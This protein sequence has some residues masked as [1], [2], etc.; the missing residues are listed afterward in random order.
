MSKT[1]EKIFLFI[2]DFIAINFAWSLHYY[3]RVE[4][5]FLELYT[6]VQF[7]LPMFVV[8]LFWVLVFG[9][10]GLYNSWYAKS[11][12]DELAQVFKAVTFGVILLFFIIFI[13]DSSNDVSGSNRSII[14]L[15]WLLLVFLCEFGRASIH[16]IQ[17]K[18]LLKGI[19]LQNTLIIGWSKKAKDLYD[20]IKK[21]P[22]LGYN[23]IGF[24]STNGNSE[25]E[26]HNNIKI[27]PGIKYLPSIIIEHQIKEVL[28]A[29]ESK[30]HDKLID[31]ISKCEPFRVGLKIMPDLYDIVT[32]QARTNQIYGFPLIDIMPQLMTNWERVIKRLLDLF[33][34]FIVLICFIPFWIL[35][36][37]GIKLE[38]KG[39]VLYRQKRVGKNGKIF[40]IMKFRSMRSDAE[41]HS[42]PQWAQKD[43][44]RVTTFGKFLRKSHLDEIPQF[45]NVLKG[46]MSL[47]GPRP[48]RPFFVEKLGEELPLYLR[49]LKVRPGITGWAQV[50]HKYDESL[51]DVKVKLQYD[52]YYIENISLK[53]DLK[54]ALS[55]IYLMIAGKGH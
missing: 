31:V 40:T 11:R 9:F 42:G 28:I 22:A 6:S 33:T 34:S 17:R 46:D 43:D 24:V 47:I 25:A 26:T 27:F 3:I 55:T 7:L 14:V 48:E 53:M 30:E 10:F 29:V 23:V 51:E 37:I 21:Y 15:Y 13:D 5:G 54:I 38:S 39:T 8:Y 4:S 16:S 52:L 1:K 45:I 41:K 36:A 44:P 20:S 2:A 49:R 50:K 12:L 35:I 18:L 19:G 32:G